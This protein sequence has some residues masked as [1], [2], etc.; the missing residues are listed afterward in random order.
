MKVAVGRRGF[1]STEYPLPSKWNDVSSDWGLEDGG[2][3][4]GEEGGEGRAKEERRMM[5]ERE[6]LG[7]ERRIGCTCVCVC[8]S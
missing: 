8:T 4:R 1:S 6:G 3:R 2:G 5:L 7:G